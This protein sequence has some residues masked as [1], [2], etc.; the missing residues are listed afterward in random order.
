MQSHK[1]REKNNLPQ[2]CLPGSKG[3]KHD[4]KVQV[5]G[6]DERMSADTRGSKDAMQIYRAE[7]KSTHIVVEMAI[8]KVT[9][10]GRLKMGSS[11]V[12][13]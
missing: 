13:Q 11:R 2:K 9:N 8:K 10:I 6:A 3:N 12:T 1:P 7:E 5:T 4:E